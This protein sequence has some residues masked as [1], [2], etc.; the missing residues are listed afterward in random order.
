[1]ADIPEIIAHRGASHL[2]PENTLASV[3]LAWQLQADAV[4]IDIHLT[5]DKRL[6]VMHDDDTGRTAGKACPISQQTLSEIRQLDAGA[7]RGPEWAGQKVPM[8]EEVLATI[9]DVKRLFVEIKGGPE[10]VAE[11]RRVLLEAGKLPEQIVIISFSL[12]AVRDAKV[13]LPDYETSWLWGFARDAS[14]NWTPS[15]GEIVQKVASAG[16]DGLD[17]EA[18]PA[19]DPDFVHEVRAAGLKL[20]TWT[21]DSPEEARRLADLGVDGITTNQ[22][23]VIMNTL[24]G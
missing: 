1:M 7:W 5:R 13:S 2:A 9:P 24:R 11:L 17:L 6:V 10:V 16:V 23:D 8:L 20:Y 12:E 4:E 22:P 21:V 15:V 3:N 19:I 14:G 18:G